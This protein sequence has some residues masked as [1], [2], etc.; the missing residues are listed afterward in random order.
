M[1][2]MIWRLCYGNDV[3]IMTYGMTYAMIDVVSSSITNVMYY[4]M[5]SSMT[6]VMSI[7]MTNVIMTNGRRD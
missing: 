6:N 3:T 4:L 7:V 5:T 1:S 2:E